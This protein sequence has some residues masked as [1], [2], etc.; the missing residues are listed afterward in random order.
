MFDFKREL[1]K[2]QPLPEIEQVDEKVNDNNI[3][4][5]IDLLKD[6]KRSG[7]AFGRL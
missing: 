7:T 5:I 4:D 2:Y 1:A 6:L 3:E